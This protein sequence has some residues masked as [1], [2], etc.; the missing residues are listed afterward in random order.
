MPKNILKLDKE[1]DRIWK[2]FENNE[3]FALARYADGEYAIMSGR[4][5]QGVDGWTSTDYVSKLGK[6]CLSSMSI[7]DDNYIYGIA[8][9][10][11]DREAY[12]WIVSRLPEKATISFSN[13]FVNC[14]YSK[15]INKFDKLKRNAVIIANEKARGK[16][17]GSLNIQKFY[18]VGGDCIEFWDNEGEQLL[19]KIKGEVGNLKDTLFVISAGPM[20]EP[21]IY[22]LYKHNPNNTYIDFG[23]AIDKYIHENI[24]RTYRNSNDDTA[25]KICT[26]FDNTKMD[27]SVSVVLNLYK[28]P[29]NLEKQLEL[30]ENQTLKPKEIILFK[31]ETDPPSNI[32]IPESIKDKV[33]LQ[34]S[35]SKNVGVWGR[36]SAGLLTKSTYVCV[37]DDD[38]MPG[39]RWLEN[40]HSA[41]LK[42]PGLYGTI[43]ILM[44]K[45]KKYPFEKY[46]RIGWLSSNKHITEVDLV[47]HSWFFKRDWLGAMWINSSKLFDLKV[48]GEDMFFSHQLRKFLKIPTYVPPHPKGAY[49]LYGSNPE[50]AYKLGQD[51][52]AL[53]LNKDNLVKMNNGVRILLKDGFKPLICRNPI[54]YYK[55]YL[56]HKKL[57]SIN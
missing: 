17:I 19:Q 39:H 57:G 35:S 31:D 51:E 28:R 50:L 37:F 12:Y 20:S 21:I 15:F 41:M 22:E 42:K 53:S 14:N 9:P 30:I 11:C 8:C 47:G 3:N 44:E 38:T 6:D 54:K 13:L 52:S 43:G 36:F 46:I 49:E 16:Q 32:Q 27:L 7:K 40:C 29:N 10:C 56:K 1:F 45:P 55:A 18:G 23:S 26:T 5:I 24:T 2:K 34:I 48:A 33:S 4:K 25:K